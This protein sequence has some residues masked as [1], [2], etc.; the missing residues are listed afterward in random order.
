MR[1]WKAHNGKIACLSFSHDGRLLASVTGSGRDVHVWDALSGGRVERLEPST[2]FS[3]PTDAKV[4][5]VAF[6]PDSELLGLTRRYCV[7]VWDA[8]GWDIK[9]QVQIHRNSDIIGALAFG[10]DST[11][12]VAASL[13]DSV[14]VWEMCSQDGDDTQIEPAASWTVGHRSHLAF[15]TCGTRLATH[16]TLQVGVRDPSTGEEIY[17]FEHPRGNYGGPICFSPDSARVAFCYTKTIESHPATL[18]DP[19]DVIRYAGHT[20]KVWALRYTPDGCSLISA[21]SDGTVR[22]WESATGLQKQCFPLNIGKILTADVSPDGTVAAV[23]GA[24][25]EI[26]V[27]DLSD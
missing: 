21:S 23:G 1:R 25:G 24:T 20:N 3:D 10:P 4:Q 13:S 7:E 15:S 26:V 12:K 5:A 9:T 16:T 2:D 14:S 22:V 27:L 11:S 19:D 6:A 8:W 18:N 17:Q